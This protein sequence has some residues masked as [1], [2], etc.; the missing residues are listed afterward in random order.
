[1]QETQQINFCPVVAKP[2]VFETQLNARLVLCSLDDGRDPL[3]PVRSCSFEESH[4]I[5]KSFSTLT[6]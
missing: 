1:M 3:Q 5:E 4:T 6:L 2:E